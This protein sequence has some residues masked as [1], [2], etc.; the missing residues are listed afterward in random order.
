MARDLGLW[1]ISGGDSDM[2][3]VSES[4]CP[5]CS[6]S[7]AAGDNFCSR[8][9]GKAGV[10]DPA[11]DFVTYCWS[12]SPVKA[13]V[14]TVLGLGGDGSAASVSGK[15]V[16]VGNPVRLRSSGRGVKSKSR[17]L[18]PDE[19]AFLLPFGVVPWLNNPRRKVKVSFEH[20]IAALTRVS[21]GNFQGPVFQCIA[22]S[23]LRWSSM[24]RVVNMIGRVPAGEGLIAA[25][26]YCKI[27]DDEMALGLKY[28]EANDKNS[29]SFIAHTPMPDK[30]SSHAKSFFRSLSA[31]QRAFR[32]NDTSERVRCL[33]NA[34]AFAD[35]TWWVTMTLEQTLMTFVFAMAMG[36]KPVGE[37]EERRAAR[38]ES[39]MTDAFLKFR[40][41]SD[42]AAC[43]GMF[44]TRYMTI[45]VK[46]IFGWD[47]KK[48]CSRPNGGLFSVLMA[49]LYAIETQPSTQHLHAHCILWSACMADL[50]D[51]LRKQD[52]NHM[53]DMAEEVGREVRS[54]PGEWDDATYE[55]A[56]SDNDV[57]LCSDGS[58]GSDV[59]PVV[60]E[61]GV[62]EQD[63]VGVGGQPVELVSTVDSE[64]DDSIV[65]HGGD[66]EY[67]GL[68]DLMNSVPDLREDLDRAAYVVCD[69]D[70]EDVEADVYQ[71]PRQKRMRLRRGS[72]VRLV[73][74][75][76]GVDGDDD[77]DDADDGDWS[78]D[79]SVPPGGDLNDVLPVPDDLGGG[80]GSL[81]DV[82]CPHCLVEVA[83][84]SS[85]LAFCSLGVRRDDVFNTDEAAHARV[86][87]ENADLRSKLTYGVDCVSAG[88][89]MEHARKRLEEHVT[90]GVS[91]QLQ[92]EPELLKAFRTCACGGNLSVSEKGLPIL[93]QRGQ[94]EDPLVLVC[95]GVNCNV[96]FGCQEV[97]RRV[98]VDAYGKLGVDAI[99]VPYVDSGSA[100]AARPTRPDGSV[101]HGV[102][103]K[104]HDH[105]K[106]TR[107]FEVRSAAAGFALMFPT[108]RETVSTVSATEGVNVGVWDV[109]DQNL[110]CLPLGVRDL[111]GEYVQ[112]GMKD[113]R[114]AVRL[115]SLDLATSVLS[116]QLH[117]PKHRSSCFK[118]KHVKGC[119]C[120]YNFPEA[121]EDTGGV[122]IVFRDETGE[123]E[124]VLVSYNRGP[125]FLYFAN[126]TMMLHRLHAQNSF[127]KMILS[128][129][130]TYYVT[131]YTSKLQESAKIL[132]ERV[133]NS[134]M[135]YKKRCET[136]P[137][138]STTS[139]GF[140]RVY[141]AM[142]A[143]TKCEV[144]SS[145]MASYLNLNGSSRFVYSHKEFRV[146]VSAFVDYLVSGVLHTSLSKNY[147]L[148]VVTYLN[149]PDFFEDLTPVEF[150][151]TVETLP[152]KTT[153]P[154]WHSLRE[155]SNSGS[156][157]CRLREHPV[158]LTMYCSQLL[159]V[160]K[161]TAGTNM[162]KVELAA[163]RE[164]TAAFLLSMGT[165]YRKRT[166]FD[167][168]KSLWD[169][170]NV[171]K[172]RTVNPIR[173]LPYFKNMLNQ[174]RAFVQDG[175]K[176]VVPDSMDAPVVPPAVDASAG[177]VDEV[178]PEFGSYEFG[179]EPP[180]RIVN[181][182]DF[183]KEV[184]KGTEKTALIK[185]PFC[186]NTVAAEHYPP[187][188]VY[189]EN[190]HRLLRDGPVRF[191]DPAS[192]KGTGDD[193]FLPGLAGNTKPSI[194][195]EKVTSSLVVRTDTLNVR[196][197]E[198]VKRGVVQD[199]FKDVD[200][201]MKFT[202]FKC[203]GYDHTMDAC[204]N[205]PPISKTPPPNTVNGPT[206]SQ[207]SIHWGLNEGQH[208]AFCLFALAVLDVALRRNVAYYDPGD[209]NDTVVDRDLNP[210]QAIIARLNKAGYA[211]RPDLPGISDYDWPRAY[212]EYQYCST[213]RCLG[214]GGPGRGKSFVVRAVLDYARAWGVLDA[215]VI[216]SSSGSSAILV[217]GCTG[218]KAFDSDA[219]FKMKKAN[220]EACMEFY[221]SVGIFMF[222]E[223]LRLNGQLFQYFEECIRKARG[224]MSSI[225]FGGVHFFALGDMAQAILFHRGM[226]ST[227]ANCRAL[228][229]PGLNIFRY[230]FNCGFELVEDERCK[231]PAVTAR[232]D[233]LA[234][235]MLTVEDL[236]E[237]NRLF[238]PD[239]PPRAHTSPCVVAVG[240][241]ID[242]HRMCRK[243]QV[244]YMETHPV[245][246]CVNPGPW[247]DRGVLLIEGQINLSKGAKLDDD[248]RA[249]VR[250]LAPRATGSVSTMFFA[251]LNDANVVMTNQDV[252]KGA[253]KG[254]GCVVVDVVFR[255]HESSCVYFK[256][257]DGLG[258]GVH[259]VNVKD[260][261]AITMRSLDPY[262]GTRFFFGGPYDHAQCIDKTD[263]VGGLLRGEF[264]LFMKTATAKV[265]FPDLRRMPFEFSCVGVPAVPGYALVGDFT[266][267]M[268]L[269]A[270]YLYSVRNSTNNDGLFYMLMSR[271]R[272][273]W[274]DLR[275]GFKLSE[276]VNK[277]RPR[278]AYMKEMNRLRSYL[279]DITGAFL[280]AEGL[281]A[282]RYLSK[283]YVI[284]AAVAVRE[285]PGQLQL[286]MKNPFLY[287]VRCHLKRYE[288]RLN[289][290]RVV[291]VKRGWVI[292]FV[293]GKHHGKDGEPVGARVEEIVLVTHDL[294]EAL[295]ACDLA[296]L[297]PDCEKMGHAD[298][299]KHARGVYL[300]LYSLANIK[301]YGLKLMRI[302]ADGYVPVDPASG[303]RSVAVPLSV[304]PSFVSAV[305]RELVLEQTDPAVPVV[306][307]PV[308]CWVVGDGTLVD[309][310]KVPGGD[311]H[312][313][314]Y[315]CTM[316][317][318]PESS[319][320]FGEP[321]AIC[322]HRLSTRG[323]KMHEGLPL[324]GAVGG[325]SAVK[326]EPVP[327]VRVGWSLPSGPV[328]PAFFR[329]G[330]VPKRVC[331]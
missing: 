274:T 49:Y 277:Y 1:D 268:T 249:R 65:S 27:N 321:G 130:I 58:D 262:F 34:Y 14:P 269:L 264:P 230:I 301:K 157:K 194:L 122:S 297:L 67:R 46:Y 66:G 188:D 3:P 205:E 136:M 234:C 330:F 82:L 247:R 81:L 284:P 226:F 74:D 316:C 294:D 212:R 193:Q 215:V 19:F 93:R 12:T 320:I 87:S 224:S 174:A 326:I 190:I 288:M 109:I 191:A 7:L 147:E 83:D 311:E 134:V 232:N 273:P 22:N 287:Q 59:N 18:N 282:R 71:R 56:F 303:S 300:G 195:L 218:Q 183:G 88:D 154:G 118:G 221:S 253:G 2:L 304:A 278:V 143:L 152:R 110:G 75:E 40:V 328:K 20:C 177:S 33:G 312:P 8:C 180:L 95:D 24:S 150:F 84:L 276:N 32:N 101:D 219:N 323:R 132:Y 45:V 63:T 211:N 23:C 257:T 220:M 329:P 204:V 317:F 41:L 164:R 77:A 129:D 169:L 163:A 275:M 141:S 29:K 225:P 123:V 140:G 86:V 263:R 318:T 170:Y 293:P 9:G 11:A 108:S 207:H 208:G 28:L 149:R 324:V 241:N 184:T 138:R 216:A 299:V 36:V 237:Y 102:E 44:I 286:N 292:K 210:V 31:G 5:Q 319:C 6:L 26:A 173:P 271:V 185:K 142:G 245:A 133:Y 112:D 47:V 246:D 179:K 279:F 55:N 51:R 70:D 98:L 106:M 281:T 255:T 158:T 73:D 181:E 306:P 104:V 139:T 222:D 265:S 322:Q 182:V 254:A 251:I 127:T 331:V 171:V 15:R 57:D 189:L 309:T 162:T 196:Y 285:P 54:M 270:L 160:D 244:A 52:V 97:I 250:G 30:L 39:I 327:L 128:M 10:C 239:F 256:A 35:A 89:R 227:P 315:R 146:P 176:K 159:D 290:G 42:H 25:D 96:R 145:T 126:T 200:F 209:G 231:D 175:S 291:G 201:D 308:G 64:T 50:A 236:K 90:N 117:D 78:E 295:G 85:H 92:V 135:T 261:L 197:F 260:V 289:T 305:S 155:H 16:V 240:K 307:S 114:A 99:D 13:L 199:E 100:R 310:G 259:C 314:V 94:G 37:S 72:N 168:T 238:S 266:Q 187:S 229:D 167:L 105:A 178:D 79:V 111:I 283:L 60:G 325:R 161:L 243:V 156:L 206:I 235:N 80:D 48:H 217:R 202:C 198:N 76:A 298:R 252:G 166:D 228:D 233:R 62:G 203:F 258:G 248:L 223:A 302:Q 17:A 151:L 192:R 21:T 213:V 120:R 153:G 131:K 116:T 280:C 115:R 107:T 4:G 91:C 53:C 165:S 272:N 172:T 242:A 124:H 43:E 214:L 121:P 296:E 137:D 148:I 68:R 69:D 103:A 313:V 61:S 144:V 38:A 267:G 119:E 113:D 186:Y 125:A